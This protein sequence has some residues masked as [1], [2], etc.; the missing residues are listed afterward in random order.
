ME[1]NT[2]TAWGTHTGL[3]QKKKK[4][5]GRHAGTHATVSGE[6]RERTETTRSEITKK[7]S[8]DGGVAHVA[9]PRENTRQRKKKE[10]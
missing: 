5:V 2:M 9:T 6:G 8:K 3:V 10:V 4:G 7:S 1:S